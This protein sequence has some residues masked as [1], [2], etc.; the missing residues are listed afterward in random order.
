MT[1]ERRFFDQAASPPVC[2]ENPPAV[3][4]VLSAAR[5]V[6]PAHG[7]CLT[8]VP[9]ADGRPCEFHPFKRRLVLRTDAPDAVVEAVACTLLARSAWLGQRP[10][11]AVSQHPQDHFRSLRDA[12]QGGI[13]AG[14]SP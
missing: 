6:H 13:E 7:L 9:T 11:T 12:L 3:E 2:R 5:C 8:F 14:S 4:R 10:V 1:A